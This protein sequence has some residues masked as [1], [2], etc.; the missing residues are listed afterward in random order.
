MIF[1]SIYIYRVNRKG[2]RERGKF[3]R[4]FLG[5]I[6]SASWRGGENVSRHG[7]GIGRFS[8]YIHKRRDFKFFFKKKRM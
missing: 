2:E 8:L 7:I 5:Q 3:D 4:K 1:K 6:F